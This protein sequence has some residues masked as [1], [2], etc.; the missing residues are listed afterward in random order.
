MLFAYRFYHTLYKNIEQYK[1]M[2]QKQA[3]VNSLTT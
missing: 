3:N 2:M 1:Q